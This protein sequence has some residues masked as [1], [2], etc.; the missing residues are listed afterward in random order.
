M[1]STE[2]IEFAKDKINDL[3]SRLG[4]AAPGQYDE[5]IINGLFGI[6]KCLL[7]TALKIEALH[8]LNEIEFGPHT[9][10]NVQNIY[11]MILDYR[12]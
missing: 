3:Y 9:G 12:E 8:I 1:D 2:I 10:D 6:T 5:T 4:E 7:D 11:R